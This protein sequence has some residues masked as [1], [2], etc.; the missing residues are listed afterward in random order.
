M[1]TTKH[2]LSLPSQSWCLEELRE[3]CHRQLDGVMGN[4]QVLRQIIIAVD[5]VAANIIQHAYPRGMKR[6][7]LQLDIEVQD[8]R[9]VIEFRDRGVPFDPLTRNQ[10]D[11]K[12]SFAERHKRGYGLAIIR[13]V[14]DEIAYDRTET[15]ENVLTL[16]KLLYA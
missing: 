13:R 15:G 12:Q 14:M 2:N 5:E 10:I 7:N 4:Q 1:Q 11:V 9:V 6:D 3:F 16:T 8:D